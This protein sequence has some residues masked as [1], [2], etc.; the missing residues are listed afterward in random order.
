MQRADSTHLGTRLGLHHALDIDVTTIDT[1]C[2]ECNHL[3]DTCYEV[4]SL[5][6]ELCREV[7]LEG[8]KLHLAV[9][10]TA[11]SID[12]H[13]DE[14]ALVRRWAEREAE[15]AILV[16]LGDMASGA[17]IEAERVLHR[18]ARHWRELAIR[19]LDRCYDLARTIKLIGYL[20]VD[21]VVD[22]V[23][24]LYYA[25]VE[26]RIVEVGLPL[27]VGTQ[28]VASRSDSCGELHCIVEASTI[29][30]NSQSLHH[31]TR[32]IDQL[33]IDKLGL[34]GTIE[35]DGV[36][37]EGTEVDGIARTIERLVGNHI[38]LLLHTSRGVV[39]DEAVG[40]IVG[41]TYRC[42]IRLRQLLCRERHRRDKCHKAQYQNKNSLHSILGV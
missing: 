12:V 42:R 11:V 3:I 32:S 39:V 7:I 17:A 21:S 14:V 40:Y 5:G 30:H 31:D 20:G 1:H 8:W 10:F 22:V 9:E 35:E 27:G 2:A 41:K 38:E 18:I 13:T 15:D 29:A 6:Q 26:K 33:D 4:T 16:G 36:D 28:G 23:T 34:G 37:Q 24:N 25:R 19:H